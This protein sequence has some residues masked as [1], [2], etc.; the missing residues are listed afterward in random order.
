MTTLLLLGASGQLGR[1]LAQSLAP[2]GTVHAVDRAALDLRDPERIAHVVAAPRPDVI[3]N[4]AAYTAVDE[5]EAHPAVAHAVNADA[6]AELARAA[7]A[8]GAL[9]VHY[10]TDYVFDGGK[11]SPYDEG[12]VPNPLNVYG[13]SKLAGENAIRESGADHLIFRTSWV[14]AAVG[15]NFVLT[16]LELAREHET[17]RVVCDQLGTPTWARRV[18]ETTALALRHDLPLRRGARFESATLHLA[19]SGATTWHGLAERVV[20]GGRR[21]GAPLACREVLPI[22]SADDPT[23]AR[24]P[25][26]SRLAV[27]RLLE[28]YR[29]GLPAWEQDLES[30]LD[31]RFDVRGAAQTAVPRS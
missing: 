30:C 7:K 6:P 17:L 11:P 13:R 19:A 28:R 18:A 27:G 1:A 29:I 15:R 23:P 12:D 3:V 5:A 10:S 14:Y 21:R 4:A 24:R 16:M 8:C 25:A 26:N 31:E 9:L 20:A 2:L 22:P